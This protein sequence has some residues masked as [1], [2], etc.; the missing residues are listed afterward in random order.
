MEPRWWRTALHAPF[1][2]STRRALLYVLI[3]LP[4]AIVGFVFVVASTVLGFG[5]VITFFGLPLIALGGVASVRLGNLHRALASRVLGQAVAVAPSRPAH[6]GFL[7]WL[8]ARLS[9]PRAWRA[10]LYLLLELPVAVVSLEAV[11]VLYIEGTV[12]LIY[13]ILWSQSSRPRPGSAHLPGGLLDLGSLVGKASQAAGESP[14]HRLTLHLGSF[15]FDTWPLALAVCL[16]GAL[17]L[18]AAPWVVR[19]LAQ[20]DVWLM[21]GLLGPTAGMRRVE[22]L[23]RARGVVADDSAATLRRIERDLHDG[24]Q[25]QLVALAMNLGDLK[26]RLEAEPDVDNGAVTLDL[27]GRAHHHAKEALTELR[28][29]A[30]GIHPPALDV[31]LGNALATLTARSAVPATLT[32]ELQSRPTEAIE[33]IAYYS[34]AELLTN[35]AK[36]S[37][38]ASAGVDV[39]ERGRRLVVTVR[40]D[41]RGGAHLGEGSGLPGLTAR[42]TAVDG[43]L[44]ISS[45]PGGP[46]VITVEL[47]FRI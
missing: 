11:L 35:V 9:D 37:G 39:S 43:S 17:V 16:A 6:P 4:L 34:V 41:G 7:G 18:L 3:G 40:D 19:A 42:L 28:S 8:Q 36:H 24:T 31:G 30:R 21:R 22:R 2:A 47:P 23:E 26:E 14:A 10:R 1:A 29:I 5:L 45:P 44:A 15:A 46:T 12:A 13:P 25:A 33:T 20:G 32:S 38:A 27:V